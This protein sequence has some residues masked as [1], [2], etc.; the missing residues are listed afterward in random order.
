MSVIRL[1][2]TAHQPRPIKM[3]ESPNNN[4]YNSS[5]CIWTCPN[6]HLALPLCLPLLPMPSSGA[7]DYMKLAWNLS[8]D[9]VSTNN[10]KENHYTLSSL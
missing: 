7:T 3:Q 8:S 4:D 5:V 10:R 2:N 9:S 1:S 6:C